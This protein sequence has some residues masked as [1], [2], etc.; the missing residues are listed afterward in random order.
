MSDS[1]HI[2]TSAMNISHRSQHR[3]EAHQLVYRE[4][5]P[6]QL[7]DEELLDKKELILDHCLID[8]LKLN[9][10]K[11]KKIELVNCKVKQL[12]LEGLDALES[13]VIYKS[14]ID[15]LSLIRLTGFERIV[16][17]DVSLKE[18]KLLQNIGRP[19]SQI[20]VGLDTSK[21]N[22]LDV[23]FNTARS[24]DL[25]VSVNTGSLHLKRNNF[26]EITFKNGN[27]H[28]SV[29]VKTA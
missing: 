6:G 13:L 11:V 9:D 5:K 19:A 26:D 24:F 15:H 10:L 28:N 1:E 21:M 2:N 27:S 4:L 25:N 23:M 8:A 20:S 16:L 17:D 12:K 7:D 18:G 14:Q 29:S 3:Y 22:K